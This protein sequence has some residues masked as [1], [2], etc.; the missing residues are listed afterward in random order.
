MQRAA[1]LTPTRF[2]ALY[3][4]IV[5]LLAGVASAATSY[6]VLHQ[7]NDFPH[8]RAPYWLLAD[9]AGNLYGTAQITTDGQDIVYKLSPNGH[10][11]WTETILY[12][13]TTPTTIIALAF[14][15]A[16]NLYG[17]ANE[18]SSLVFEL[19]PSST[20]PWTEKVIYTF[21]TYVGGFCG[22][23]VFDAAGN[24]Y[25]CT[26]ASFAPY[27]GTVFELRPSS[28][29]WTEK[30]LYTFTGGA[31]GGEPEGTISFD[32]VGNLYGTAAIGGYAKNGVAYELSPSSGVWTET[33]LYN[34]TGG[35]DGGEPYGG[36]IF[37]AAG[38]FYGTT[39]IGGAAKCST[40]GGCGTVF[41]LSQGASGQWT[42]NVLY[43]FGN[44]TPFYGVGPSSLTM[45]SNGNLYG[46]TY[47]GGDQKCSDGCGEVFELSPS[48]GGSWTE[49]TL[50]TF[51]ATNGDGYAPGSGAVLGAAGQLFGTTFG[52][53]AT[54]DLYGTVYELTPNGGGQWTENIIQKF[55]SVDVVAPWTNLITDASAN[56]YGVAA[57]GGT[58]T[59]GGIYKFVPSSGNSW[60]DQVIYSIQS[61]VELASAELVMDSAG[62]L[63]GTT[64]VGG[65][66][67]G[68][69][70]F[71]LSLS[72]GGWSSKTIFNFNTGSG[73]NQ[74]GSGLAIDKAGNLYGTTLLGGA[75]ALG[76]AFEL[77]P[78]G[79][80][81]NYTVIHDFSGSPNDGVKPAASMIVDQSG[82]LYGT[83]EYGGSESCSKGCGTVFELSPGSGGTWT[84]TF[85][86]LFTAT[87]GRHPLDA[88]ITDEA[89]NLYGTT[90]SGGII[91]KTCGS[92][93]CGTVF[94]LSPN[95][96]GT[97]T[98]TQ[99]YAFQGG[100][101][102][103]AT[104]FAS[105]TIDQ[106]GNLYGTT[107]AGG[108]S[109]A[110]VCLTGCGTIFE[111]S[112][113]SNG[114]WTEKVLHFFSNSGGDGT[115]PYGGLTFG[116]GGALYGTTIG[117]G[118]VG[119][120]VFFGIIP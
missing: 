21:T 51:T 91:N 120:G 40:S 105:L 87:G 118:A 5:L 101:K 64:E 119:E 23:I 42:E 4:A 17:T 8:G 11:G 60:K 94:E 71:E 107:Y 100:S 45:D 6:K 59:S 35:V 15:S 1:F 103:G 110:G 69:T 47:S 7:F 9:A 78:T 48:A 39:A 117:G 43:T 93:G 61:P 84:E 109:G 52:G 50:H 55:A 104:P 81:W 77:N 28:G 82:N 108:I 33:V 31:D 34:F 116:S 76:T 25:S 41:K 29:S 112:P 56:L 92:A 12:T 79:S 80:T 27:Y 74:P 24:L 38:N 86:Y 57:A 3:L 10:G 44:S 83:T 89:G 75:Y 2:L 53:G 19:S 22:G 99:L 113:D 114:G 62:N 73:G 49:T 72:G 88:L 90:N 96:D 70:V 46:T 63:Y 20:G 14:D 102:D 68:G 65:L 115:S 111:L 16:G 66:Y 30:T 26:S 18:A 95:S 58:F 98:E 97:W 67:G 37:D 85:L 32:S 36:L 13:F 106:S 54:N